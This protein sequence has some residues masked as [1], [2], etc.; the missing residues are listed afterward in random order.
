[1]HK[2]IFLGFLLFLQPANAQ[3]CGIIESSEIVPAN[4][5]VNQNQWLNAQVYCNVGYFLNYYV[6][7]VNGNHFAVEAYYCK[8]LTQATTLTNDSI[9]LGPLPA[10]N[11]TYELTIFTSPDGCASYSPTDT[12]TGAWSVPSTASLPE[13]GNTLFRCYP[14]PAQGQ[15]HIETP[16]QEGF[17]HLYQTDGSLVLQEAF[18]SG[19]HIIDLPDLAPGIYILQYSDGNGLPLAADK[20]RI[21]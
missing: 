13:N 14:N 2:L 5:Q 11:Y 1:M 12:T 4:V 15:L 6:V 10:G 19:L 17:I 20:L 21:E 18:D 7:N 9:P 3:Y 16:L 8:T